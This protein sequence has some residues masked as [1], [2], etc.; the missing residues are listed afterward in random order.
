M[1]RQWAFFGR[2]CNRE[3]HFI[4]MHT[5]NPPARFFVCNKPRGRIK[6]SMPLSLLREKS[7]P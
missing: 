4:P 7:L 3:E 1:K 5:K 6:C 2:Y